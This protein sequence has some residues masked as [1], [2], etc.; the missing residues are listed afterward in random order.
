LFFDILQTVLLGVITY[1]LGVITY[2]LYKNSGKVFIK[3]QEPEKKKD[4]RVVL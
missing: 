1:L 3:T 4:E 2:L